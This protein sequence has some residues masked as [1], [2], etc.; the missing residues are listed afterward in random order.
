MTS[1]SNSTLIEVACL[2]TGEKY[3]VDKKE[4]QQEQEF[5][6]KKQE[7]RLRA[8]QHCEEVFSS[9]PLYQKHKGDVAYWLNL[10]SGRVNCHKDQK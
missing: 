6:Q 8:A 3:W 1:S 5:F 10:S 2:L 4:H 7:E 9:N